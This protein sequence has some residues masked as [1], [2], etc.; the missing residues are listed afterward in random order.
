[1]IVVR[2]PPDNVYGRFK[3]LKRTDGKYVV[4]DTEQWPPNGPVFDTEEQARSH[5]LKV[6]S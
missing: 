1:M 4:H 3:V 6:S 2:E 5:A